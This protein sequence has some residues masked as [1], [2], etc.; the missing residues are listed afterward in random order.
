[1][2]PTDQ[3]ELPAAVEVATVR[4]VGEALVN[5]VR[6]ARAHSCTVRVS[7]SSDEL[8]VSIRDDGVGMSTSRRAGSTGG[9]GVGLLSMRAVAE[10]IGGTLSVTD[11]AEGGTDVR[12]CLPVE[13][14]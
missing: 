14:A 13:L 4:V 8:V 1:M 11:A 12:L 5:A 3:I 7:R 6:H 10:E 2:D 9:S